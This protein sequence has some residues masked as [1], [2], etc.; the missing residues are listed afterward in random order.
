MN[1]TSVAY[2]GPA[3]T[4]SHLAAQMVQPDEALLLPCETIDQVFSTIELRR[5]RCGLVPLV[6]TSSGLVNDT[7][8]AIIRRLLGGTGNTNS[9]DPFA[10]WTNGAGTTDPH[11]PPTSQLCI[12]A[13]LVVPIQHCLVSWG[14]PPEIRTV[15]SKQQALDQCCRWLDQN[16]P[17]AE[18]LPTES[19][20][21]A[22]PDMSKRPEHAAIVSRT[23]ALTL[24][25][26]LCIESIQDHP[27]NATEFVI[28]Q[29]DGDYKPVIEL[30]QHNQTSNPT[31]QYLITQF[32]KGS[33]TSV[34]G[35]SNGSDTIL[36][37]LNLWNG[38]LRFGDTD[39]KIQKSPLAVVP[40]PNSPWTGELT[41]SEASNSSPERTPSRMW[42]LGLS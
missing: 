27:D 13:S 10:A 3:H 40:S 31:R 16:L 21:A 6:N 41:D 18:R 34:P 23:A 17:H 12:S 8:Q 25:A 24:A 32:V 33:S 9:S 15:L 2:L 5:A 39:Y 42:R 26:P 22:L 37:H 11:H 29:L 20:A 4:Y 30:M 7:I 38:W 28:V 35:S 36:S 19:S 1:K 14:T